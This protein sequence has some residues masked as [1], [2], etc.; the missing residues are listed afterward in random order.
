M[1]DLLEETDAI[2]LIDGSTAF[3]DRWHFKGRPLTKEPELDPDGKPLRQGVY[4]SREYIE[5]P[6]YRLREDFWPEDMT[7][8]RLGS[9]GDLEPART[10]V[11][12][13]RMLRED[14]ADKIVKTAGEPV[15]VTREEWEQ[16]RARLR[17]FSHAD[18][19]RLRKET[20]VRLLPLLDNKTIIERM[21]SEQFPLSLRTVQRIRKED[22]DMTLAQIA[23]DV[24]EIKALLTEQ[25][26]AELGR[27]SREA[28]ISATAFANGE[29]PADEWRSYFDAK[30]VAV[31]TPIEP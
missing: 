1:V 31:L 11:D 30:N 23:A 2:S 6:T 18:V 5:R 15:R 14:F 12:D 26:A 7:F 4:R 8:R 17:P 19:K 21:G 20:I 28:A 22:R 27:N 16:L 13:A 3:D 24:R 29:T 9:A 25:Q 10:D